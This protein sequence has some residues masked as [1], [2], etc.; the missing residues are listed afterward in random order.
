MRPCIEMRNVSA[1]AIRGSESGAELN[2]SALSLGLACWPNMKASVGTN[3]K[4]VFRRRSQRLMEGIVP[5][6]ARKFTDDMRVGVTVERTLL[7]PNQ[8]SETTPTSV[9]NPAA[10]EIA[11]AAVVDHL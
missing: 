9:T 1:K 8:P 2:I 4:S 11:P 5:A 10:Q 3:V 7:G 6:R